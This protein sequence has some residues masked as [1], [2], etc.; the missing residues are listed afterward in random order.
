MRYWARRQ[1]ARPHAGRPAATTSAYSGESRVAAQTPA[2]SAR[3]APSAPTRGASAAL[4]VMSSIPI[5]PLIHTSDGILYH[6]RPAGRD[7][8]GHPFNSALEVCSWCLPPDLR[9]L[10]LR[11]ETEGRLTTA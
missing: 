7:V 2:A 5:S 4:A 1:P 3:C 6:R 8:I 10:R 9:R 11:T